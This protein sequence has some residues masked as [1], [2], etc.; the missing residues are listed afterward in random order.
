VARFFNDNNKHM[1]RAI[2]DAVERRAHI[3]LRAINP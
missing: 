3:V 2:N 1:L